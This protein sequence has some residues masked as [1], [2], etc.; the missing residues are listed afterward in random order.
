MT[1]N[2]AAHEKETSSLSN[3]CDSRRS[4]DVTRRRFLATSA[5]GVAGLG[6]LGSAGSAAAD[7]GEHTLE[8]QGTGERTSYSFTVGDNLSGERL[9]G[10]DEIIAQSAHG[11]V[12]SGKDIYTFDGELY[13][14]DF[15]RSGAVDVTLDGEAAHVGHRPDHTLLI[16]GFG[17]DV[18]YSLSTSSIAV[19]TDAYGASVNDSDDYSV[20]GSWGA[21]QAGKD[22]YT[23]EGDLL[24]FD[25][26]RSGEIRVT[27]DGKAAHVGRRPDRTLTIVAR[28]EYTPYEFNVSGEM[29]E[30]LGTEDGQ[31]TM[32][33]RGAAGAVSGTGSDAYTFDGELTALT[34]PEGTSPDIYSNHDYVTKTNY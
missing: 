27:I 24:S 29:R 23:Y 8:I 6:A 1:S 19:P 9:T 17:D 34:Y 20:Y 21:V 5:A 12:K 2:R 13:S 28:E 32:T 15:D 14:F 25:F 7:T 16:E 26:D 22:A 10:E 11:E 30:A 18:S 3:D 4:V 31:D 33:P